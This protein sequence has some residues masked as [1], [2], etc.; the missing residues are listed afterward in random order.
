MSSS[1]AIGLPDSRQTAEAAEAAQWPDGTW[2][3]VVERMGGAKPGG[4][5]ED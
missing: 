5:D 3:E 2:A 4:N 1:F